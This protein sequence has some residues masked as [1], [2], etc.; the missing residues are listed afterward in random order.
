MRELGV[1]DVLIRRGEIIAYRVFDVADEIDLAACE[2]GIGTTH[3]PSRLTITRSTGHALIVRNA[4]LTLTLTPSQVRLGRE[5][6][7]AEQFARLW[8]YGV[9]S[10]HFRIAIAEGT[11]WPDLVRLAAMAEDDNDFD[12]LALRRT[13]DLTAILSA[14]MKSPHDPLGVEDYVVYLLEKIDGINEPAELLTTVDVPALILGE[15]KEKISES[16]SSAIL[17]SVHSYSV[18][19][20]AVIDWNSALLVEPEGSRDV[21]DILEFAVTHLM[22]FETFDDLLDERLERLYDSLEHRP[23]LWSFLRNDY[24]R[25]SREARALYIEFSD[26]V[27]RVENSLKFVGDFYLATIFRSAIAKFNLREWE[28][29]VSRKLNALAR[30]SEVIQGDINT[31]RSHWLEVIV[32]VLILVELI[33]TVLRL[34]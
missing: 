26:Y 32:V 30:I 29:S 4:P 19:D 11:T 23:S 34:A 27:E 25:L 14:T 31:R 5:E 6:F 33:S 10:I 1:K 24:E 3:G 8:D 2:Q 7:R 16:V 17:G 22:E 12:E 15:P 21:A 13:Q 28:D 20:L 18:R 9:M